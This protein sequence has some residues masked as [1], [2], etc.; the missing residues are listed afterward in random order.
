MTKA[1]LSPRGVQHTHATIRAALGMAERS[2]L[3]TRNVA[4]LVTPVSVRRPAVEPFSLDE[5][6]KLL[7][8][9][10]DHRLG[11]FTRWPWRWAFG[12][13]EA[14]A[15]TWSDVDLDGATPSI[16][17]TKALKKAPTGYVVGDL[18]TDRA[19]RAH[20]LPVVV[21]T[22]DPRASR[23]VDPG[24]GPRVHRRFARDADRRETCGRAS[25]TRVASIP[26]I[27]TTPVA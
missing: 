21:A 25:G 12:P 19:R 22:P 5:V 1:G 11:A 14:L 16:K 20:C 18:K 17:V 27:D 23:P 7:R 10:S 24:R 3:V 9:A 2:G 6:S 8:A 4:K 13:Q 26:P 15:L